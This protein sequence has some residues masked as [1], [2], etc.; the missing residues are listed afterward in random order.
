MGWVAVSRLPFL[1]SDSGGDVDTSAYSAVKISDGLS[2]SIAEASRE[3]IVV[4]PNKDNGGIVAMDDVLESLHAVDM[5]SS[6]LGRRSKNVSE[7]HSFEI[8]Y[9]T[10]V[11]RDSRTMALQYVPANGFV[12]PFERQLQTYYPDS[13]IEREDVTFL[14]PRPGQYLS[15]A[16]LTLRK[17]DLHP[18]KN[19]DLP[20][21]RTDPIGSV[22]SEMVGAQRDDVADADVVVQ[23]VFRPA[24]RDWIK[25]IDGGPG[26]KELSH[27][28]RQPTFKR[29][30]RVFTKETIEYPPSD[31]D[32]A[33][34]KLLE[35]QQGKKGWEVAVR[36]VAVSEAEQTAMRR[37]QQTATM[38]A[39]FYESNSEQTFDP[40]PIE[41]G[42]AEAFVRAA[43]DREWPTDSLTPVMTKAQ[44]E[45]A[46]LV[47]VPKAED[48]Q[49]NKMRWSLSRPGE[50]IP[51]GT[52]RF[53]FEASGV[54]SASD[55]EKMLAMLGE[56]DPAKPYWYG[57]GSKHGV[58]AGVDPEVLNVHQ[59]VG[60]ATGKGKTTWL[61]NLFSQ[62]VRRG[63]GALVHD[64]KGL[65][66]DEFLREWPEDRDE[67]DLI[68]ID[69]SDDFEKQVR[70]NFLEVPS[71]GDVDSRAYSTAVEALADDLVAMIA[72]A[73][74]D[75]NYWGALMNRVTRTLIRGMAKSNR[76]CT[77][78]DLA[79]C[80]TAPE[81]RERFAEWMS[82]ERIHF[83]EDAAKRIRDKEERDLE[84][85][86]GRLDQWV[87]NDAIRNLIS[88]RESTVSIQKAVEE[89]K[90]IVVRNAP[91]SGETEK[92]LFATALI[93]RAWCAAREAPDAPPF[94]VICDEFDSIVTEESNI[95]SIL[96]EARAFNF[97]LT[98]ACQN[99]SNQL[100]ETVAKAIENQCETFITF[101]PGGQDDARLIAGQHS[102]DV[103]WED[104]V[105]IAKYRF[106]MRT[107]DDEHE[108]THS[109]KVN[110]FRPVREV[111][112]E[113][114]GVAG[115][116]D[117]EL[118][119]FKRRSIDR[120]GS[121]PETAEQQ[122]QESHFYDDIPDETAS[123]DEAEPSRD[124]DPRILVCKAVYD[125]A[126]ELDA[127]WVT[128]NEADHRLRWYLGMTAAHE[129]QID[130][131]VDRAVDDGLEE[132]RSDGQIKYKV[133][134]D[135]S[136]EISA[137]GAGS[138]AGTA[139]HRSVLRDAYQAFT[140]WGGCV[141]IIDQGG[142]DTADF[143][144]E[145]PPLPEKPLARIREM[146]G[147]YPEMAQYSPLGVDIVG[148]VEKS[149]GST[150]PS[151]TLR[152]FAE[153]VHEDCICL[154]AVPEGDYARQVHET[155]TEPP[156]VKRVSDDRID[157][158]MSG[159]LSAETV[160][161]YRPRTGAFNAWWH[162]LETDELVMG[163]IE[164]TEFARVDFESLRPDDPTEWIDATELVAQSHALIEDAG[165][166]DTDDYQRVPIPFVPE[167]ADVV[168]VDDDLWSI[169]VFPDTD[170][171]A[172]P[173]EYTGEEVQFG[174][175][176]GISEFRVD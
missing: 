101:N 161:V 132:A 22:M 25:G 119:A 95:H 164:G 28:L 12:G 87:Q 10:P 130:A 145:M 37:C 173:V 126:V 29:Q 31:V 41:K 137:S 127:E 144:V 33:V 155:M 72:Q 60:G 96:S 61:I 80:C 94:Y 48:V 65:D 55:D 9:A 165:E 166:V 57:W 157:Y 167:Y 174:R 86:A 47:N 141:E 3:G 100:P 129:S 23:F 158:Y 111:R 150:Q 136:A 66:A 108:L 51:P 39:N 35:D 152:N 19:I 156:L 114:T 4:R 104:L 82:E 63:N 116:S 171:D 93:R 27:E 91:G 54:E 14:T 81:N 13:Q 58:E 15:T 17:Y 162:D 148:E 8:R 46:G 69:L 103:T 98:L 170:H 140:R 20:G 106:Y 59:F 169:L 92:R 109:Y 40:I 110:A 50:G 142:D 53:D 120:Y 32:K 84:P 159:K 77:L 90:V 1:G 30:W 43:S 26:I 105:N 102:P 97:C 36:I 176:G 71:Q 133:N 62:V 115:M 131:T 78:L 74:G 139:P 107:H 5:E 134:P 49:T 70:F 45:L 79:C 124:A 147:D 18:I 121:L 153:A 125:T 172:D 163:D 168:D 160:P 138:S 151:Q 175:T 117:E 64:P 89:G 67:E 135:V 34:A 24:T 11:G 2:Q 6:F 52:P 85:L 16:T 44:R 123:E 42:D 122:K 88:A 75:D 68:F 99:P 128:R 73:G 21:F 83:I 118:E 113:L 56:T 154:F 149:T 76:T 7:S 112:Q 143:R 38:F 146:E